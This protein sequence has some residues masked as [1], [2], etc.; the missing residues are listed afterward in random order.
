MA[1]RN[2]RM[3]E[4]LE[5]VY[6]WHRG[7]SIR[8][9]R[10][11]LQISRKTI[12]KYLRLF[13]ARGLSREKPLPPQEE[14][15]RMVASVVQ[16][17]VFEQPAR[18]RI[19]LYHQQIQEW[20]E[21]PDM[22]IQQVQRLLEEAARVE[23][24]LH[25]RVPLCAQPHRAALQAGDGTDAFAGRRAGPGRLRLCRADARS[26]NR[27][28]AQDLGLYHD[29]ELQS[30]PLR[31]LC[32]WSGQPHLAG[33]S[34]ACFFLFSRLSKIACPGQSERRCAEARSVRS[35]AQP[36]LRRTGKTL[37]IRGRPG[38]S[39]DGSPQRE[40]GEMCAGG[41][42][43]DPG[44]ASFSGYRGGQ[45]ES[46]GVVSQGSR[47]ARA[48]H[49]P[50]QTLRGVCWRRSRAAA[51][52]ARS[53]LRSASVETMHR[54]LGLPSDPGQVLLLGPLS[55]PGREAVGAG[56]PEAG[57]GV[58]EPSVDQDPRA[59]LRTGN[60]ADP[61]GRL[62]SRQADLSGADSR[63]VPAPVRRAGARSGPLRAAHLGRSRHAQPEKGPGRAAAGRV[64]PSGY[65]GSGLPAG[66]AL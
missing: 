36:G 55:L 21:Q 46:S 35:D 48:W 28:T 12:R 19:R 40:S 66:L 65:S 58:S 60:L 4:Y 32:V 17:A 2:V 22:T 44:G 30:P 23:G 16:V 9:I 33:L 29:L 24:Q 34:H 52:P 37:W 31:A 50:S 10:D 41:A 49:H 51:A 15:A 38:K 14:L 39:A 27:Q 53:T 63:V 18:E 59:G 54:A 42:S 7:R 61:N 3:E 8:Q 43:A 5:L 45:R 56:R 26:G 20:L 57:A 64:P 13:M 11:S 47:S 1:R 6:Q 62:S 25:E